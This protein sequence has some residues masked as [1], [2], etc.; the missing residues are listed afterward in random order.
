MLSS[1]FW[2]SLL[3]KEKAVTEW[4]FQLWHWRHLLSDVNEDHLV[5][6]QDGPLEVLLRGGLTGAVQGCAGPRRVVDQ[7]LPL[8]AV[9]V[10]THTLQII[11]VN[12][13]Q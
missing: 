11:T 8:V 10:G 9:V 12:T 6:A 3:H 5:D 7:I 2:I 1:I 4:H 13:V